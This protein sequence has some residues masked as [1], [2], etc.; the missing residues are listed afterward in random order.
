MG[1]LRHRVVRLEGSMGSSRSVQRTLT[2]EAPEGMAKDTVLA[3][4]GVDP[5]EA[6]TILLRCPEAKEPAIVGE[7]AGDLQDL[8]DEIS[9]H[10]RRISG[11]IACVSNTGAPRTNSGDR[12]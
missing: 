6:D 9:K 1:S 12:S 4:L 11:G 10:G 8:L 3:M 7:Y 5:Q 2:I